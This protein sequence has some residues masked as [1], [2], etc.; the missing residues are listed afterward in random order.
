M[1]PHLSAVQ[2]R[3][4]GYLD[5]GSFHQIAHSLPVD[6]TMGKLSPCLSR[7][8]CVIF[9]NKRITYMPTNHHRVAAD[10]G[11]GGTTAQTM[12]LSFKTPEEWNE[13]SEHANEAGRDTKGIT[14]EGYPNTE[15]KYTTEEAQA[16]LDRGQG[17]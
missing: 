15:G 10:F 2:T 6:F 8:G 5:R 4:T 9:H 16:L 12:G 3:V 14:F 17:R 1:R 7:G 11:M 13:H